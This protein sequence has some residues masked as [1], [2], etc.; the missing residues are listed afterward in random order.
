VTGMD[1]QQRVIEFVAGN[2]FPFP[3]QTDWPT[4]YVT[5][6]NGE[7]RN[8]SIPLPSGARH[9]PDIVILDE[10]GVPCRLGEVDETVDAAAVER[11]KLCSQAADTNN[12]TGVRNL[13]VYVPK[14]S[15][16]EAL[17]ALD[18]HSISFAGLR[19]YELDAAAVRITPYV[20]RGDRYDHQ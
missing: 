16:A 18:A 7:R 3:G 13:F 20:T 2:R 14:G 17:A 6:I 10:K 1:D 11:W 15:G 19:E 4:G 12:E 9:W 5:L 8:A